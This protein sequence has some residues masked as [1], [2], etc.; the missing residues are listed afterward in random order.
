[1]K[2][3]TVL[4]CNVV[5]GFAASLAVFGCREPNGLDTLSPERC[6]A[7]VAADDETVG[8]VAQAVALWDEALPEC[9]LAMATDGRGVRVRRSATPL[10]YMTAHGDRCPSLG[11]ACY[12][13]MGLTTAVVW[14]DGSWTPSVVLAEAAS[15][16]TALHEMGH[17]LA[18][19]RGHDV[20]GGLMG[21]PTDPTVTTVDARA[22]AWF[23]G[24]VGG[25]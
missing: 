6:D 5:V 14:L 21:A 10:G 3:A 17:V 7:R 4:A 15:V 24:G 12:P 13:V 25:R 11:P 9:A 18:F 20:P 2:T 23:R 19:D 1:V 8:I 16:H 22:V